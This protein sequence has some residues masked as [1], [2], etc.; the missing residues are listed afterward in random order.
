MAV[1]TGDGGGHCAVD[2][3]RREKQEEIGLNP[4]P[5]RFSPRCFRLLD[6]QEMMN[7]ARNCLSVFWSS[8]PQKRL[9]DQ[10]YH[11]KK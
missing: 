2:D 6:G 5:P 11:I 7:S 1:A 3:G 9:F 4:A 10:Y 8:S